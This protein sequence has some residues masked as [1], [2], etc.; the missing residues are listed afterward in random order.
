MKNTKKQPTEVNWRANLKKAR[1]FI[2]SKERLPSQRSDD[3]DERFLGQW[4]KSNKR[5][6]KGTNSERE[7]M[8]KSDIPLAYA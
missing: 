5:D 8:L 7:Q 3:P 1:L 2:E 4:I 6:Q